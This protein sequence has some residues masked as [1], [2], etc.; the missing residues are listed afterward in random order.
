MELVVSDTFL[1]KTLE[2]VRHIGWKTAAVKAPLVGIQKVLA[3]DKDR[4]F[5]MD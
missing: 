2:S 1:P 5:A 4:S 3:K